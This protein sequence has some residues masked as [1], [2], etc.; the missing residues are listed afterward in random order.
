IE[1]LQS[2]LDELVAEY[3][4]KQ[5]ETRAENAD[6]RAVWT[7][8]FATRKRLVGNLNLVI[9]DSRYPTPGHPGAPPVKPAEPNRDS[10]KVDEYETKKEKRG[11]KTVEVKE[12]KS[13]REIER[14]KDQKFFAW[15]QRYAVE[16]PIYDQKIATYRRELQAWTD[17]DNMRRKEL[18]DLYIELTTR[19]DRIDQ[20]K[21]AADQSKKETMEEIDRM[22]DSIKELRDKVRTWKLLEEGVRRGEHDYFLRA[23]MRE[24]IDPQRELQTI[25]RWIRTHP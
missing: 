18:F 3:E 13:Q 14:E 7:T 21:K 10:I 6:Q 20:E 23:G 19:I 15:Q 22:G 2:A 5:D 16:K 12:R 1:Q 24:G 11:D 8:T 4:S 9:E 25:L 17:L